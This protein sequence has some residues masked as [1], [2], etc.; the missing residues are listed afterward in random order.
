[1]FV[2]SDTIFSFYEA[3]AIFPECLL[4]ATVTNK[5]VNIKVILCPHIARGLLMKVTVGL[6]SYNSYKYF[7]QEYYGKT[8]Q[9]HVNLLIYLPKLSLIK[10]LMCHMVQDCKYILYEY[11]C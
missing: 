5:K 9:K 6:F 4:R 3:F 1:M 7:F 2:I 10:K 8:S 11:F